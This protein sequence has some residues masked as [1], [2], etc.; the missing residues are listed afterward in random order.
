MKFF[1]KMLWLK[2][3][4]D[5]DIVNMCLKGQKEYLNNLLI[6]ILEKIKN[7][8]EKEKFPFDNEDKKNFFFKIDRFMDII[9]EF[10]KLSP[11]EWYRE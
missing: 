8:K 1:C 10:I 2:H 5:I 4:L 6:I 9:K 7:F 11:E 3:N